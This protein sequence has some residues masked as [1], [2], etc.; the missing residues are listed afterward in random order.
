MQASEETISSIPVTIAFF[1]FAMLRSGAVHGLS[2]S[3]IKGASPQLAEDNTMA[4]EKDMLAAAKPL[5]YTIPATV[6]L[7][8]AL[9]REKAQALRND[10]G[11]YSVEYFIEEL[12]SDGIK[13]F[14]RYLDSNEERKNR[15]QFTK[16][17]NALTSPDISNADALKTYVGEVEKLQ[18]RFRQGSYKP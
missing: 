9:V 8:I 5:A 14:D 12:L 3:M 1:S 2:P 17:M 18:R 11:H 4:N 15:E 13:T 10:K 16:A 6:A 7:Q